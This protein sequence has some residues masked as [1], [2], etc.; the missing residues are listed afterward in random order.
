MIYRWGE[1]LDDNC[2]SFIHD[3]LDGMYAVHSA[4]LCQYI[5]IMLTLT[6]T[7]ESLTIYSDARVQKRMIV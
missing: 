6:I 7:A 5:I 3:T 2:R 4:L 1:I